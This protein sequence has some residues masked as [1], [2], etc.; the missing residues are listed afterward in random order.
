MK[1]LLTAL[2]LL[3]ALTGYS[4]A[5]C[6]QA[7]PSSAKQEFLTGTHDIGTDT[8]K[9]AFYADAATYGAATTAYAAT[10]EVTGTGYTAGGFTV[11]LSVGLSGTTG[12]IDAT[13]IA[14]TGVT[15]GS[16]STCAILYNT[17]KTDKALAVYTFDSVQ[18]SDGTLTVDFPASGASTSAIRFAKLMEGGINALSYLLSPAE[19]HA[20]EPFV[21]GVTR[22]DAVVR[23]GSVL[24]Q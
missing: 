2:I 16:A 17:S 19:A 4:H 8:F 10:N 24:P 12:I 6:T 18:P 23:I 20:D 9:L 22:R 5:A 11:T 15:F 21:L 1:R 7:L 14:P 13:D 3:L